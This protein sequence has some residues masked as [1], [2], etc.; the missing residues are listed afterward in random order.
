MTGNFL[1][2]ASSKVES[3]K[4]LYAR[5]TM[6]VSLKRPSRND[7]RPAS[8]QNV[9]GKALSLQVCTAIIGQRW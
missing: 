1:L 5:T 4:S 9:Y 6:P 2:R 3:R 8:M 7:A